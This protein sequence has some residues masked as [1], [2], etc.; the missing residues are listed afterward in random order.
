MK[1]ETMLMFL[2]V[3]KIGKYTRCVAVGLHFY[4][5]IFSFKMY[6]CLYNLYGWGQR[7]LMTGWRFLI[8]LR[9]L[10]IIGSIYI[11]V[12]SPQKLNWNFFWLWDRYIKHGS[13]GGHQCIFRT[14]SLWLHTRVCAIW[15]ILIS[16]RFTRG[17]LFDVPSLVFIRKWLFM[18]LIQNY[19][20]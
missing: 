8:S 7:H 9:A 16:M 6:K 15:Y 10:L 20:V 4:Q 19:I 1:L 14:V 2:N 5:C 18:V 17:A 3:Y 13:R 11:F 12:A